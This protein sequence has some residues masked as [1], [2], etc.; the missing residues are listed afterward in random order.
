MNELLTVEWITDRDPEE[1]NDYIVTFSEPMMC[2]SN[3]GHSF[4]RIFG[5]THYDPVNGWDGNVVAWTKE[6]INPYMG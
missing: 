1:E 4:A 2:D 5:V 6:W 3:G